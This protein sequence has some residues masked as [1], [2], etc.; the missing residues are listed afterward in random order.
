MTVKIHPLTGQPKAAEV[1][2]PRPDL[3]ALSMANPKPREIK[4]SYDAARDS[5]EYANY[6]ANS[7]CLDA[8]SANSKGVRRKLVA[9]SRYEVANNGYVDGIVQTFANFVVGRGP[10]LRLL[11]NNTSFNQAVET[12]WNQWAKK[13]QLRRKL[14]A[15]AHAKVQDGESFAI[16]RTNPKI[17]HKVKLDIVLIETEQCQ[18]PAGTF[19]EKGRI[20]GI[21]FDD[22]GNPEFY[23]VLRYHPGGSW[24][25][26]R[27]EETELVPAKY[28]LHWFML[29]RPGQHRGVPE[30]RSTLNVGA[31]GRRYREATVS[32]AES[33]AELGAALIHTDMPAE[34]STTADPAAPFSSFPLQR[35]M[36]TA[37][38]MGWDATQMKAE[39]P[40][41]TYTD[42]NESL[43]AESARPKNMPKNI[44]MCD[45][46]KYNYASGRLDHQ[47]FFLGCDNEREDGDDLVLEKLFPVFW[48]EAVLAYGWNADP[49]DPPDHEFGWPKYPTADR[50]SESTA[51]DIDLKNG[52]KSPSQVRSENGE[53][54]ADE[55][56]VMA[57]DYGVDEAGMKQALFNSNF[58]AQN[59]QASMKQA[60]NAATAD[61][62][63]QI[64]AS[65]GGVP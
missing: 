35:R 6:W 47:T 59:Q 14:W 28:M 20:D 40:T 61:I 45:S 15:M 21:Y 32:A 11:T 26:A 25:P 12:V 39:Q 53:D 56:P 60:D 49:T 41:S 19:G 63:K 22:F 31:N 42:F 52:T 3:F 62:K 64:A 1:S 46:S 33:A 30:L 5:A 29:R 51:N 17:G 24:F 27:G 34:G 37:L 50:V 9:R 54:Y 10:K 57:E 4:A 7:D 8:D 65:I 23:E 48:E 55:L 58:N 38:P 13:I 2:Q 43:I 18:S 36:V 44:A 16:I